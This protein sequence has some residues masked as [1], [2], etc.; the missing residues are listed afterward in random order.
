MKKL[1]ICIGAVLGIWLST[2]APMTKADTLKIAASTPQTNMA[3]TWVY[4]SIKNI[5]DPTEDLSN[6]KLLVGI[7]EIPPY[8]GNEFTGTLTA[9]NFGKEIK[10]LLKGQI[11]GD[12]FTMIALPGNDVTEG[13][14]Y[15]YTGWLVPMWKDGVKQVP[16]FV[17]SVLR[18]TE[19]PF[20]GGGT[21]TSGGSYTI[22]GMK[23][24]Q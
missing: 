9:T 16:T 2:I 15:N 4:R 19:H 18:I 7:I 6:M 23:K 1:F 5:A 3:G 24:I 10:H 13:W 12:H 20:P 22:I 21:S 8:Q 17:G 11:N 14:L